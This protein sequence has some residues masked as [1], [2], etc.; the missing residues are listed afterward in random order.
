[1][2][3]ENFKKLE[4]R[5]IL[6][7]NIPIHFQVNNFSRKIFINLIKQTIDADFVHLNGYE[8][9]EFNTLFQTIE[10][11]SQGSDLE[12]SY[13]EG[14]LH[15]LKT[16]KSSSNDAHLKNLNAKSKNNSEDTVNQSSKCFLIENP[17]SQLL[18]FLSPFF[19]RCNFIFI[20]DTSHSIHFKKIL[21]ITVIYEISVPEIISDINDTFFV[22]PTNFQVLNDKIDKILFEKVFQLSQIIKNGD[23][24][25]IEILTSNV[26]EKNKATVQDRIKMCLLLSLCY[27]DLQIDKRDQINSFIRTALTISQKEIEKFILENNTIISN[28][29]TSNCLKKF[30]ETHN[31]VPTKQTALLIQD[32][33][34]ASIITMYE[35]DENRCEQ[36]C[37][38][39][40][41]QGPTGTGKTTTVQKIFQ[42]LQITNCS[43]DTDINDLM[44]IHGWTTSETGNP[45]FGFLP[46]PFLSACASNLPFLFDEMNLLEREVSDYIFSLM[47][48]GSIY[49]PHLTTQTQH[50]DNEIAIKGPI[51]ININREGKRDLLNQFIRITVNEISEDIESII[52]F[53]DYKLKSKGNLNCF[54]DLKQMATFFYENRKTISLRTFIRIINDCS[55]LNVFTLTGIILDGYRISLDMRNHQWINNL[56]IK[57]EEH[58][59]YSGGTHKFIMTDRIAELLFQISHCI[60][61][62]FPLLLHGETSTGKT[63]LIKFLANERKIDLIR[64]NNH[65]DI[66]KQDYLGKTIIVS[67]NK[68][69]ITKWVDGPLIT[70]IKKDCWIL[71]DEINLCSS[72]VLE[73]L[74]RLLDDNREIFYNNQT[75]KP[76]KNFRI[77]AT[78]NKNYS[79][80][81]NLS[82]AFLDRWV[83]KEVTI[84]IKEIVTSLIK[85]R[86]RF[87][88]QYRLPDKLTDITLSI[89]NDLSLLRNFKSLFTLRDFYKIIG[90]FNNITN[91]TEIF[92]QNPNDLNQQSKALYHREIGLGL[93]HNYRNDYLPLC[94]KSVLLDYLVNQQRDKSHQ[95]LIKNVI[96]KHFRAYDEKNEGANTAMALNQDP[97]LNPLKDILTDLAHKHNIILTK[98]HLKVFDLLLRAILNRENVLLIG[99]TGIGKTK[100]VEILAQHLER[101]LVTVCCN[102]SM[103]TSDL[104]GHYILTDNGSESLIK[105]HSNDLIEF[106]PS[107]LVESLNKQSLILL[108]E[109]NLPDHSVIERLNSLFDSYEL[110]LTET[111]QTINSNSFIVATMNPGSYA[112]K[113]EL[114]EA[115]RNR[116][117][118]I[119]CDFDDYEEI[120]NHFVDKDLKTCLVEKENQKD[121]QIEMEITFNNMKK[122]VLSCQNLSIRKIECMRWFLF[123]QHKSFVQRVA[124]DAH[125]LVNDALEIAGIIKQ[126]KKELFKIEDL[127]KFGYY[128]FY[129]QTGILETKTAISDKTFQPADDKQNLPFL[130]HDFIP[131]PTTYK[132]STHNFF[133][134]LRA[135]SISNNILIEGVPGIGKTSIVNELGRHLHKNVERINLNECTEFFDLIGGYV[136]ISSELQPTKDNTAS[137]QFRFIESSFIKALRED[138]IVILDE[139]NLCSQSVLEGLNS[140]FDFRKSIEVNGEIIYTNSIIIGTM[141]PP[142]FKGRNVLPKS[143]EDRFVKI[144]FYEYDHDEIRDIL[145]GDPK[146]NKNN[147]HLNEIIN[148]YGRISLRQCIRAKIIGNN[149]ILAKFTKYNLSERFL[150]IG[151]TKFNFSGGQ[152]DGSELNFHNRDFVFLSKN[153]RHFE[154]I[155]NCLHFNIPLIVAGIGS[156]RIVKHIASFLNFKIGDVHFYNGMDTADLLGQY[157]KEDFLSSL[158]DSRENVKACEVNDLKKNLRFIWKNSDLIQSLAQNDLTVI[159]NANL[160]SKNMLDR[161]NSLL[162]SKELNVIEKG[163]DTHYSFPHSRMVFLVDEISF[164][165]PFIDRCEVVELEDWTG[166]DLAKILQ[167]F[168]NKKTQSSIKHHINYNRKQVQKIATSEELNNTTTVDHQ[169]LATK[170]REF[171]VQIDVTASLAMQLQ[172]LSRIQITQNKLEN[173]W[174]TVQIEDTKTVFDQITGASGIRTSMTESIDKF[175]N[176]QNKTSIPENT[177]LLP[178]IIGDKAIKQ[179]VNYPIMKMSK[180]E[181]KLLD[182]FHKINLKSHTIF[183]AINDFVSKNIFDQVQSLVHLDNTR[184]VG[185]KRKIVTD[186]SFRLRIFDAYLEQAVHISQEDV[187]K[188]DLNNIADSFKFSNKTERGGSKMSNTQDENLIFKNL[189]NIIA[190]ADQAKFPDLQFHEF[191]QIP[192]LLMKEP[193]VLPDIRKHLIKMYKYSKCNEK[194]VLEFLKCAQKNKDLAKINIQKISKIQ[195]FSGAQPVLIEKIKAAL[196]QTHSSDNQTKNSSDIK[197]DEKAL[198]QK[199]LSEPCS[200]YLTVIFMLKYCRENKQIYKKMQS[201]KKRILKSYAYFLSESTNIS[202]SSKDQKVTE[203]EK[204]SNKRIRK[205]PYKDVCFFEDL[206]RLEEHNRISFSRSFCALFYRIYFTDLSLNQGQSSTKYYNDFISEQV[207][208]GYQ[209]KNSDLTHLISSFTYK[210][211]QNETIDQSEEKDVNPINY[212]IALHLLLKKWTLKSIES[213]ALIYDFLHFTNVMYFIREILSSGYFESHIVSNHENALQNYPTLE[214]FLKTHEIELNGQSFRLLYNFSLQYSHFYNQNSL[215]MENRNVNTVDCMEKVDGVEKMCY[216]ECEVSEKLL[217]ILSTGV[218][219]INLK[220][221]QITNENANRITKSRECACKKLYYLRNLKPFHDKTLLNLSVVDKFYNRRCTK[222]YDRNELA[223]GR[224]IFKYFKNHYR[225]YNDVVEQE[226]KN[227]HFL[228]FVALQFPLMGLIGNIFTRMEEKTER[229]VDQGEQGGK[230]D[231]KGAPGDDNSNEEQEN[232]DEPIEGLDDGVNEGQEAKEEEN[233]GQIFDKKEKTDEGNEENETEKDSTD[234]E[235]EEKTNSVNEDQNGQEIDETHKQ[236][237]D[238]NTKPDN[239]EHFDGDMRNDGESTSLSF[240]GEL[241]DSDQEDTVETEGCS[242]LEDK[243][244]QEKEQE[245]E[246]STITDEPSF[247]SDDLGNPEKQVES[248]TVDGIEQIEEYDPKETKNEKNID[249]CCTDAVNYTTAGEENENGQAEGLTAA[250]SDEK[251]E[252]DQL[253][254]E[255]TNELPEALKNDEKPEKRNWKEE[256]EKI[257]TETDIDQA[258]VI[259]LESILFTK[260]KYQGDYKS[261]KK[262]NLKKIIEFIASDYTRDKIWLRQKKDDKLTVRFFID[263]TESM[264]NYDLPEMIRVYCKLTHCLKILGITVETY[265]FGQEFTLIRKGDIFFLDGHSGTDNNLT[266]DILLS[267]LKFDEKRT[268]YTFLSHFN[269][270]INLVFTDGIVNR[271]STKND[272]FLFLIFNREILKLTTVEY[273]ENQIIQKPYLKSFENKYEIVD[274]IQENLLM[275]LEELVNNTRQ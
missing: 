107:K 184:I 188:E 52:Q 140:L 208:K 192:D 108:D 127:E 146:E 8:F 27:S 257:M 76:G 181:Y 225:S 49:C 221:I 136:P 55:H 84:E 95:D 162:D 149:S 11:K 144:R 268:N 110:Y 120:Y 252:M 199:I 229:I 25:K 133:L 37:V 56:L 44:G 103:D 46:G 220:A 177:H 209:V 139:I 228:I 195:E 176:Q 126:Q 262:L 6:G 158:K 239:L 160:L 41:L 242:D 152:K 5:E 65:R 40:L 19:S 9:S 224:M 241:S 145:L 99:E 116:F 3:G 30:I 47:Q 33:L 57:R 272:N 259:R 111:G 34:A 69:L 16:E 60:D 273:L 219:A 264:Q 263:N 153:V 62:N 274:D 157:V 102:G 271:G 119:F 143:F 223:L 191:L 24:Y 88:H 170:L 96:N 155:L 206:R 118:E 2:V 244:D 114:S 189:I 250:E 124:L 35:S 10:I 175:E 161:L 51:F 48:R 166:I 67:D 261:G 77:F 174:I 129:I 248:D 246:T 106:Q 113:K 73:I 207:K 43:R 255:E 12:I 231:V 138:A 31:L 222:L 275:A 90:R 217:S 163:T 256:I 198:I 128:P 75:I 134:L 203:D 93:V 243:F 94:L 105:K 135:L 29:K 85:E 154:T 98:S 101:K 122:D 236:S 212:Q 142:N 201:Y 159:H 86:H 214:S 82:D 74:N 91:I 185:F 28:S 72:D 137:L 59:Y 4:M 254:V 194:A 83:S 238:Q 193:F 156:K 269:D 115:L 92:E 70:A 205:T 147:Q 71:I 215:K 167:I 38:P 53:I 186:Q 64:V 151:Q 7:K 121:K 148:Y 78:M 150:K 196:K 109:I 32:I 258:L 13:R 202:E 97:D 123:N 183:T 233:N 197:I 104:I 213:F 36:P 169:D 20:S 227:L 260:K 178:N 210:S 18:H 245:N 131:L 234:Q 14:P 22:R 240:S 132:F 80:R 87:E 230:G 89:Y 237:D 79:G 216:Q 54:S 42:N 211:Y 266:T 187:L 130:S 45:V 81:N 226:E 112:G 26:I 235:H 15:C 63:S 23:T 270:G 39:I 50:S 179:F 249:Q 265:R 164:S 247:E 61:S 21:H 168:S 182:T 1:M 68:K 204:T 17:T 171:F 190:Q 66:D 180:K 267:L 218:S 165:Q 232:A 172:Y 100:I 117:T 141:N 173:L 253:N 251:Q 200:N 125:L 58:N